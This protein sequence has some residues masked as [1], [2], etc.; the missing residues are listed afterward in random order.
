MT[1]EELLDK[2]R[3]L[4]C[5]KEDDAALTQAYK[6][7]M[8]HRILK[9][10]P[11]IWAVPV[12]REL[13]S[14]DIERTM[15]K[16][17]TVQFQRMWRAMRSGGQ[18]AQLLLLTYLKPMGMALEYVKDGGQQITLNYV[19]LV[20]A[21]NY[22]KQYNAPNKDALILVEMLLREVSYT[23]LAEAAKR[24]NPRGSA[25]NKLC[26]TMKDNTW[27]QSKTDR[28]ITTYRAMAYAFALPDKECYICSAGEG[29]YRN[30][31]FHILYAGQYEAATRDG[32]KLS[33]I[34]EAQV[35]GSVKRNMSTNEGC[36][37]VKQQ[38]GIA[39]IPDFELYNA[40]RLVNGEIAGITP[41]VSHGFQ[42][43]TMPIT[44]STAYGIVSQAAVDSRNALRNKK[45][46]AM[47]TYI[48]QHGMRAAVENGITPRKYEYCLRRPPITLTINGSNQVVQGEP[49][50]G[51]LRDRKNS[52]MFSMDPFVRTEL[53]NR[54]TTLNELA[55]KC[56]LTTSD[57]GLYYATPY[58]FSFY[59]SKEA[60]AKHPELKKFIKGTGATK[61]SQLT[62][63]AVLRGDLM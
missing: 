1:L 56:K 40:Q 24:A 19:N 31:A 25:G 35:E 16:E 50:V 52:Y 44:Q 53:S 3:S 57:V 28:D 33:T 51:R 6:D 27:L 20:L 38:A 37:F 41:W 48:A 12:L 10:D 17:A 5:I 34:C 15:L 32:K 14:P 36:Y 23:L 42:Y 39:P 54:I 7:V 11:K 55:T 47:Q 29:I 62:V 4:L 46:H 13:W 8:N 18:S 60:L 63:E 61:L 58:Y 2:D 59:C 21:Y 45:L 30:Y 9:A 49:N 43:H 22:L 26:F